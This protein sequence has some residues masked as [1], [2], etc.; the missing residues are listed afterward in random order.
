MDPPDLHSVN[1]TT[2]VIGAPDA[3]RAV[4]ETENPRVVQEWRQKYA[5][6]LANG[7]FVISS[8]STQVQRMG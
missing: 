2:W 4:D 7:T 3:W 1:V 8:R 6:E 5:R